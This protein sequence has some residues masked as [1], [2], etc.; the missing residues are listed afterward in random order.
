ML[1]YVNS[2]EALQ[3]QPSKA[4]QSQAIG[5]AILCMFFEDYP[6]LG[7]EKMLCFILIHGS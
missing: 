3:S 6:L 4:K 7:V 2:R 5:Y 1:K